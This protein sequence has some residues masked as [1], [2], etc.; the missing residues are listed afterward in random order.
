MILSQTAQYAL[1]IMAHIAMARGARPL[2]AKEISAGIKCP[3]PYVSKV[4]R[5]LVT[6]GLL[7]AERG[8]GGGFV[9]ARPAEKVL[10]CQ[11][12]EAVKG[13]GLA[14]QC[15]FGWRKCDSA[16]PCLL[17]HR[18]HSVS[19]AFEEWAQTTSLADVQR[20]AKASNWLAHD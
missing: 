2:R 9:L 19:G 4:L 6:S 18:W 16:K 3:S 17:H 8:H 13:P 1:R 5:R 14:R 15:I 12:L 20:D 10:F 11:V 7:K